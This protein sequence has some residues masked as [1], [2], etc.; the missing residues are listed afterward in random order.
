MNK[1][2]L[3]WI[4]DSHIHFGIA[5]F[6][7]EQYSGNLYA[8]Y[9]VNHITKKF[10]ENQDLVKFSKVW[11]WR[12]YISSKPHQPDIS[13]LKNFENRNGIYLWKLAF[14]ERRFLRYNEFHKFSYEE[15][16]S[17]TEDEC[18]IFEKIIDEVKP[19][20]LI[21]G[22]TDLHK[23]QLF[24]EICRVKGTQIL[25]LYHSRFATRS[26]ISNDYDTFNQSDISKNSQTSQNLPYEN[27]LKKNDPRKA[28]DKK[29]VNREQ[30]LGIVNLMKK[31]FEFLFKICNS[32]YRNYY[33]NWGRTRIRFLFSKEFPLPH[34]IKR[35][36]RRLYL[37]KKSIK[38]I[39]FNQPFI[40]YP[41]QHEPERT[42]LLDAPFFTNQIEV[43]TNLAKSLPVDFKLY[44]KEHYSMKNEAWREREY[45]KKIKDL[46]NVELIHPTVHSKLLLSNCSL[47]ATITGTSALEAGFYKKPSIIFA[48]TSFSY[49]PFI[50][51]VKNIEELPDI[52]HHLLKEKF[53]YSELGNYLKI[54]EDNSF[55]VNMMQLIYDVT[56]QLHKYNG[57][58]REVEISNNK[59]K[60][61]LDNHKEYFEK[62]AIEYL[63]KIKKS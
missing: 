13:Y 49:L 44:V 52:I 27:Y 6:L 22:V 2:I 23:N 62:L 38:E 14:M 51:K 55:D 43:I 36:Y 19:G 37:D 24:K 33:E 12:D 25:M 9:D 31:N 29:F 4:D 56:T 50:T 26:I 15:I 59:M 53:D 10:Y 8:V 35:W 39:N 48:D 40:Y 32:K 5:K 16:L 58:L 47:V 7:Q 34:L 28:T 21:I 20:Y 63:N 57:S 18:K 3:F 41:L 61:F 45:Y 60:Y 1:N 46:P 42:L 54:V 17:I 30:K 11:F